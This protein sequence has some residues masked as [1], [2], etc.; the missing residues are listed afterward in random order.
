VRVVAV[1]VLGVEPVC[2]RPRTGGKLDV[3]AYLAIAL[4]EV[5]APVLESRA[6]LIPRCQGTIDSVQ[7]VE[8]VLLVKLAS[9]CIGELLL[10]DVLHAAVI[11]ARVGVEALEE[12]VELIDV[13]VA[14]VVFV[15]C[16]RSGGVLDG[17]VYAHPVVVAIVVRLDERIPRR[18][19]VAQRRVKVHEV[20][21]HQ[22]RRELVGVGHRDRP[23]D[24][25]VSPELDR[26]LADDRELDLLVDAKI[27][28]SVSDGL[29]EFSGAGDDE[30]T[31]VGR[32]LRDLDLEERPAVFHRDP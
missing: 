21:E 28:R 12:Q 17:V 8:Q 22:Q 1:A 24:D 19:L 25:R 18:Q 2:P 9:Q 11:H 4:I 27:Q 26:H 29:A 10:A 16:G 23:F 15:T 6:C 3:P 14:V 20:A 7:Q 31:R 30:E 5:D 13:R 32:I